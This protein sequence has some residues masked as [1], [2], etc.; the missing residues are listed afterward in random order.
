MKSRIPIAILCLHISAILLMVLAVY[1]T[2]Y[3][4]QGLK[5]FSEIQTL[6]QDTS[7]LDED[8]SLDIGS[9]AKILSVY[10]TAYTIFLL[11]FAIVNEL[12][13]NAIK[14]RKFW[15]WV[16]GLIIFGLY[17]PSPF[18]PLGAFGLW[19]LLAPGSRQAFGIA[20]KPPAKP[21][22]GGDS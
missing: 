18:L 11:A 16:V 9:M 13:A 6:E 7:F 10:A 5:I 17:V 19:G 21:Y 22:D 3:G 15:A 14:K 20:I 8:T 1:V 2:V 12:V 4:I